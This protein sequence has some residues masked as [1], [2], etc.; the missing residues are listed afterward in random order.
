MDESSRNV[1]KFI[2]ALTGAILLLMAAWFIGKPTPPPKPKPTAEEI[3]A[4]E[5]AEKK[6]AEAAA[7]A[8]TPTPEQQAEQSDFDDD[9]F[10]AISGEPSSET[11]PE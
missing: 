7:P 8:A 3:A 11:P 9:D 6:A 2:A 1:V 10:G 5:K 4:K